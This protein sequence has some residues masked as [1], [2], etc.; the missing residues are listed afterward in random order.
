VAR[1]VALLG[2]PARTPRRQFSPTASSSRSS[3]RRWLARSGFPLL[4]VTKSPLDVEVAIYLEPGGAVAPRGFDA[5][6][7]RNPS[8]SLDV[9]AHV[10]PVKEVPK[11]RLVAALASHG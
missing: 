10:I 8:M 1:G 2:T 9:Y 11:E 5:A 6:R 3:I 7:T 4:A